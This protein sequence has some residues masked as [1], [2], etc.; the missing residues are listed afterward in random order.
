MKILRNSRF[1]PLLRVLH[2]NVVSAKL[3]YKA[4]K[5]NIVFIWI[6][7]S[8]G[9]SV[10]N[11]LSDELCMQK[12]KRLKHCLSFPNRGAVT[13][14][15]VSYQ[16]LLRLGAVGKDF[17]ANAYK[18]CVVRNPYARAVSAYNYLI[19]ENRVN[20]EKTFNQFL[21]DVHLF[22][23]PIGLYNSLGISQAN[24]QADWVVSENGK[25]LVDDVFKVEKLDVFAEEMKKKYNINF[26]P[27][28]RINKPKK[29]LSIDEAYSDKE[30][31]E[32]V[33]IIYKRDFDLFEYP[34]DI[35]P[36]KE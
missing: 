27:R 23:E 8:A 11:F 15:H 29:K 31:V 9:S 21:H 28:V 3:N 25:L 16:Q 2:S 6:P 20:A 17:H 36:S 13:F 19:Q 10:F 18:F 5:E 1:T 24:P 34:E 33:R 4:S 12:R 22:R 7:K 14:G 30:C 26:N 32:L 35:V